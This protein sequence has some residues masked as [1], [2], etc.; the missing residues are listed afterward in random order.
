MYP[1]HTSPA[2]FQR[3][4]RVSKTNVYFCV[5][6]FYFYP[7]ILCSSSRG[8]SFFWKTLVVAMRPKE[9]LLRISIQHLISSSSQDAIV[10]AFWM[11]ITPGYHFLVIYSKSATA[12][13]WFLSILSLIF[14]QDSLRWLWDSFSFFWNLIIYLTQYH[15]DVF[16]Q[17]LFISVY[18]SLIHSSLIQLFVPKE[19][20]QSVTKQG[21]QCGDIKLVSQS[22]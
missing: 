2:S 22:L 12:C 7:R 4:V 20:E 18:F 5:F 16:T 9:H 21:W 17:F 6:C 15:D 1:L 19:S 3:F 8:F 11:C 10:G 13:K 14:V